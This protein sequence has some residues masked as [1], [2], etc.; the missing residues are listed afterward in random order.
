M[1][2][3]LVL[4]FKLQTQFLEMKM[5]PTE[6]IPTGFEDDTK[7]ILSTSTWSTKKNKPA[8]TGLKIFK[9]RFPKE[10]PDKHPDQ[11]VEV[12]REMRNYQ[13]QKYVDESNR[14]NADLQYLEEDRKLCEKSRKYTEEKFGT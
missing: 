12:Y 13:R 9:E 3:L 10:Y 14:R 6:D 7:S 11:A 1:G 5:N 2:C 4:I 8:F